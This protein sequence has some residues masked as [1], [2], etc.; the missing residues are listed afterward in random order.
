MLVALI[1]EFASR[2][3]QDHRGDDPEVARPQ[4]RVINALARELLANRWT[5]ADGSRAEAP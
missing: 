5:K 3:A 2:T 1:R 4:L